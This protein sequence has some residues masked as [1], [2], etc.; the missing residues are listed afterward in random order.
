MVIWPKTTWP[1]AVAGPVAAKALQCDSWG[2]RLGLAG[3]ARG[4]AGLRDRSAVASRAFSRKFELDV[5]VDR[6]DVEQVERPAVELGPGGRGAVGDSFHL[7]KVFGVESAQEEGI[8]Q[9]CA[10]LC[11]ASA[12][13]LV[14]R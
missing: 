4:R 13:A 3:R 6:D 12:G 9:Q 5:G 10:G 11:Q 8:G 2:A 7:L 14:L 1:S